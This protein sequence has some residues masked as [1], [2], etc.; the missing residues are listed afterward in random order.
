M[1][2]VGEKGT[3][4]LPSGIHAQQ[5]NWGG[6]NFTMIDNKNAVALSQ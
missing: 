1:C 2:V 5:V 6:K 3:S 4:G